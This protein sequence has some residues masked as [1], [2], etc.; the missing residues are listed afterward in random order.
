MSSKQLLSGSLIGTYMVETL[1]HC[2]TSHICLCVLC[3]GQLHLWNPD[4][5]GTPRSSMAPLGDL[6]ERLYS[7]CQQLSLSLH[8]TATIQQL[9]TLCQHLGLEV[10]KHMQTHASTNI[11]VFVFMEPCLCWCTCFR[12]EKKSSSLHMMRM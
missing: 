4:E 6:E 8:G 5:P 11:S 7:T 9:H 12:S 2:F 10:H 1:L 3:V